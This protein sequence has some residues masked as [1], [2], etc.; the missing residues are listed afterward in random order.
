MGK[1]D[2]YK[3]LFFIL[4]VVSLALGILG[5]FLPVLPTTPFV[6][7]S[8]YLFSTSSVRLH[9]WLIKNRYFGPA[10]RDWQ[11]HRRIKTKS[12]VTAT[13]AMLASIGLS[14][15]VFEISTM[16]LAFIASILLC[17]GIFIWLQP[18]EREPMSVRGFGASPL[19]RR[20][21]ER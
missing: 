21:I 5:A 8:A 4:G 14:V 7:L 12:K 17:V 10:I 15:F 6:L 11:N 3:P 2:I 18:S 1:H 20:K 19:T 16:M 13:T 9:S